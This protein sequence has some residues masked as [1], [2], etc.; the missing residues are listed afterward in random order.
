VGTPF[1]DTRPLRTKPASAIQFNAARI[2]LDKRAYKD[3][4]VYTHYDFHAR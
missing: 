3:Q 1:L 4:C 2:L